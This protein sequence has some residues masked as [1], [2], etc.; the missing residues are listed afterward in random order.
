VKEVTVRGTR[1]PSST[2]VQADAPAASAGSPP[3]ASGATAGADAASPGGPAP[4]EERSFWSRGGKSLAFGAGAVALGAVVVLAGP[5]GWFAI[6]SATMLLGSGV[7]GVVAST[8]QL[9]TSYGGKTTAAE[10][11]AANEKISTI[12]TVAG[13]PGGLVGGVVGAEYSAAT[14]GDVWKGAAMGGMIGGAVEGGI[15]IGKGLGSMAINEVKFGGRAPT[16]VN[17]N[18]FSSVPIWERRAGIQS[19]QAY[20][21]EDVMGI[22]AAELQRPNQWF[23]RGIELAHSPWFPQRAIRGTGKE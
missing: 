6:A 2:T 21:K 12:M 18:R 11:A 15:Y 7:F 20:I 4:P 19:V 22:K 5:V 13:S 10:D 17:M 23:P 1:T 14:G 16:G 8:N 3:I 9:I